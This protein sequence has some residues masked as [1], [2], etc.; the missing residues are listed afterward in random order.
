M[1]KK[2]YEMKMGGRMGNIQ[3]S[4]ELIQNVNIRNE[5]T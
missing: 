5:E 2:C 1:R 3:W 4:N